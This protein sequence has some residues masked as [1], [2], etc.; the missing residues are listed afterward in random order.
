MK[1][2]FDYTYLMKGGFLCERALLRGGPAK[3]GTFPELRDPGVRGPRF[4][5]R[6]APRD[7]I[8]DPPALQPRAGPVTG[9][10][11][12]KRTVQ[13]LP[14]SKKMKFAF[15]SC[16]KACRELSTSSTRQKAH[17]VRMLSRRLAARVCSKTGQR[18]S[19][20]GV[21]KTWAFAD[22]LPLNQCV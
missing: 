5:A 14:P 15:D 1:T 12:T 2:Q 8:R 11:T 19:S 13:R 22:S 4:A 16:R 17:A 6:A 21:S 18:A 20:S 7:D 10:R 9:A 3:P